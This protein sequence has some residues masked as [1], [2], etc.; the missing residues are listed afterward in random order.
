MANLV[1]YTFPSE[2]GKF[3]IS[4]KITQTDFVGYFLCLKGS[5]DLEIDMKKYHLTE[6]SICL[7][8]PYT[9]VRIVSYSDD[10]NGLGLT[11]GPQILDSIKLPNVG[12]YF[13]AVKNCP[14][15]KISKKELTSLFEMSI[16]LNEKMN[17]VD[18][19]FSSQITHFLSLALAYEIVS[20][21]KKY[22]KTQDSEYSRQDD[23][24]RTF[25]N[26]VYKN[27]KQV[28]SINF[29]AEQMCL[30]SRYLSSIIKQ[31]TGTPASHWITTMVI[32]EAK[33]LLKF[34]E[35]SVQQIAIELNFPNASFFGQY[36][37]K[38]VGQTPNDYRRNQ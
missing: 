35:Y 19:E 6:C 3:P 32:T 9:K 7:V 33:N 26:L 18:V 10:F 27:Y 5:A 8:L 4:D 28:R 34:S 12:E 1:M 31:K 16:F 22:S 15:V 36:F 17:V 23:I 37:R 24:F 38:Y 29:Y 13:L 14:C 11:T 20:Y 21:Y 30:T 2:N 25:I